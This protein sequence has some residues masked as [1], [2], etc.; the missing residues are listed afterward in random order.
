MIFFIDV[1]MMSLAIK[2]RGK[3]Y[4]LE[5]NDNNSISKINIII[6]TKQKH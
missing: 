4:H 6:P 2:L 3:S 5:F 1:L